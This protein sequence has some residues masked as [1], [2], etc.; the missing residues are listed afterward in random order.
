MACFEWI[1]CRI[2]IRIEANEANEAD[3]SSE[4]IMIYHIG[5][6]MKVLPT[7]RSMAILNHEGAFKMHSIDI[8][9]FERLFSLPIDT[10][11]DI[12]MIVD[13]NLQKGEQIRAAV[14]Y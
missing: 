9:L 6:N 14:M 7:A 11:A 8:R 4:K 10:F 13:G 1:I 5:Y 12:I 2:F 3:I